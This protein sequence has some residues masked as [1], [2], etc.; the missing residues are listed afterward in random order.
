MSYVLTANTPPPIVIHLDS[1]SSGVQQLETGKTTNFIYSLTEPVVI[2]DHMN[3]LISLHTATIPYSFY[4]VRSGVNNQLDISIDG[5]DITSLVLEEGNYSANGLKNLIKTHMELEASITTF[6]ISYTRETLKFKIF[7]TGSATSVVFKNTSSCLD[8]LGFTSSGKTF[9]GKTLGN[10]VSSDNAVD[11]NDAIHG[12]YVRQNLATRGTLDTSQGIF[13]NILARIPITT[14]AGG[15]IFFTPSSNQHETMI[16][17]PLIQTIGIRI[18]DDKHRT[19]DLNGLHFQ[20]SIKLSYIHKEKLREGVP[21][22][23]RQII[24][25]IVDEEE[26]KLKIKERKRRPKKK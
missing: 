19:I 12:L 3:M 8:L 13:S 24:K 26:E 20:L 4:N 22:L 6:D 17:V 15:I 18:T 21:R 10:A 9:T 23:N 16:S 25:T 5:V 11:L 2:P 14:N 1:Q 7:F